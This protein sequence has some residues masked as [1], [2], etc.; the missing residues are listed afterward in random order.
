[1]PRKFPATEPHVGKGQSSSFMTEQTSSKHRYL[2]R[3]AAATYPNAA[4]EF[5]VDGTG[6]P[7]VDFDIGVRILTCSGRFYH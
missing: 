7:D 5:A 2:P 1:M 3:A 4:L 6:L